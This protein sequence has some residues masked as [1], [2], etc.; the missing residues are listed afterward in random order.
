MSTALVKRGPSVPMAYILLLLGW[1]GLCGLHRFYLGRWVSGLVWLLT[2][3]L[4]GFG[5]VID[6]FFVPRMAE[7]YRRGAPVW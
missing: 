4:L 2:F 1:F 5:Q 7:D 6:I 3:G